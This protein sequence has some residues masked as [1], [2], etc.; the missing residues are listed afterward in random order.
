MKP[1]L[2]AFI[3]VEETGLHKALHRF[4]TMPCFFLS[5]SL[6]DRCVVGERVYWMAYAEIFMVH[7]PV[8]VS[9]LPWI[10]KDVSILWLTKMV[11][12]VINTV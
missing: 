8:K 2:I 4:V 9:R 7:I 10:D 1:A 5:L 12:P 6:L 11:A 3:H